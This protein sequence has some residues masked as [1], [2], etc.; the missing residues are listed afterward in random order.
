MKGE[1]QEIAGIINECFYYYN[2]LF[3]QLDELYSI[4]KSYAKRHVHNYKAHVQFLEDQ[5]VFFNKCA[6]R[7]VKIKPF[8]TQLIFNLCHIFKFEGFQEFDQPLKNGAFIR[9]KYKKRPEVNCL[10]TA[11]EFF[12]DAIAHP[13]HSSSLPSPRA[14]PGKVDVR[15]TSYAYTIKDGDDFYFQIADGKVYMKSDILFSLNELKK[16]CLNLDDK[17][18]LQNFKWED[19]H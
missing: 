14:F 9:I 10:K 19:K 1:I 16:N 6:Q 11:I 12:R 13:E 4:D 8:F 17:N 2:R 7:Q 3:Y 18:I 15:P 5:A